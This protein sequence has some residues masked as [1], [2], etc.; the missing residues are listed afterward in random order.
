MVDAE[1]TGVAAS[2]GAGPEEDP[3]ERAVRAQMALGRFMKGRRETV[4]LS[5]AEVGKA[6]DWSQGFYAEVEKGIKSSKDLRAWFNLADALQL[7]RHRFLELLWEARI[8]LP[9][10]LPSESDPRRAL[11]LGLAVEQFASNDPL[12]LRK[13]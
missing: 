1:G 2:G 3:K 4:G 5:Q 13:S 12:Q 9:L 11:V 7:E 10:L 6:V 8:T